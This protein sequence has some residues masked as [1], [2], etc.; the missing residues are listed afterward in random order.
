MKVPF[1]TCPECEIQLLNP[2]VE[3]GMLHCVCE[4]GVEVWYDGEEDDE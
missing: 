1:I 3:E 4:C 2:T